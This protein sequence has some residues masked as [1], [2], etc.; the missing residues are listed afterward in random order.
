[1]PSIVD[2]SARSFDKEVLEEDRPVV[3]EFF[4]HSCPHCRKFNSV[5]KKLTETLGN[6]AK[7]VKID[8]LLSSSNRTLTHNRGV[9]RVPALEVFYKG[10]VIGS[11]MGYHHFE[12]VIEVLKDFLLKKG[13]YVGPGTL[14]ST[15]SMKHLTK[16][17][18]EADTKR[19]QIRW[20]KTKISH[21][22]RQLIGKDLQSMQ[23]IINKAIKCTKEEAMENRPSRALIRLPLRSQTDR[24]ICLTIEYCNDNWHLILE[25]PTDI[26]G[27]IL[28][29]GLSFIQML[30][31]KEILD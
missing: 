25:S 30:E 1:M 9:R 8:V 14:L 5:Y 18:P 27:E 16:I 15:L 23:D 13:E 7:F 31:D 21:R 10:R 19:F 28:T 29:Q 24:N 20:L 11:V 2:V 6:E 22:D 26:V 12:K 3:V 4:S 17:M